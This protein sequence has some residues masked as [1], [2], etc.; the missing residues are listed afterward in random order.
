[1]LSVALNVT[2]YYRVHIIFFI[3]KG[4]ISL[5]SKNG[6]ERSSVYTGI[7]YTQLNLRTIRYSFIF[8]IKNVNV[9]EENVIISTHNRFR[10]TTK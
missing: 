1:M 5:H 7:H 6:S 4:K 3:L 2:Y 8:S 9:S 10:I